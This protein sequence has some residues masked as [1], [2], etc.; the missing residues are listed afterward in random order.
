MKLSTTTTSSSSLRLAKGPFL[1]D[2][3]RKAAERLGHK[4]LWRVAHQLEALPSSAS[5]DAVRDALR[6]ISVF[7]SDEDYA[8]MCEACAPGSVGAQQDRHGSSSGSSMID[9]AALIQSLCT[10]TLS[11]RRQH[12]VDLVM[13][14]LDPSGTG[15]VTYRTLT[16]HYDVLR[17]PDVR[18]GARD[19][20]DVLFAFFENFQ[21][22]GGAPMEQLTAAE[23]RLYCVGVS[24]PIRDDTDF[25]LWC[26]RAFCLDRP[27]LEQGEETARLAGS[28]NHSRQSRLLGEG[29]QH[30]LFTTSNEEYGKESTRTDYRLPKHGR[31]Q[32]FTRNL[33][34]RTGGATSMNM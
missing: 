3:L 17:H 32:E 25:E 28:R 18:N 15:V 8:H 19:E 29:R 31:P 2:I 10:A 4:Q 26:T 20:D 14:K 34:G 24:L 5:A 22:P 27:K 13:R 21:G 7:L 6:D 11:P 1:T 33:T 16:T 23:L 30:P 9:T 12:V